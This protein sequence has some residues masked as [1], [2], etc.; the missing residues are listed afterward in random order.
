MGTKSP[1]VSFRP[2]YFDSLAKLEPAEQ[3]RLN[4]SIL[5][6][7]SYPEALGLNLERLDGALSDLM[8]VRAGRDRRVILYRQGETY[9]WWFAGHHDAA[10]ERAGRARLVVNP[11]TE[12]LGFVEPGSEPHAR[13]EGARRAVPV[14]D[15]RPRPFDHWRLSTPLLVIGDL[16]RLLR[17]LA[18]ESFSIEEVIALTE[19]Y[20][21]G[22]VKTVDDLDFGGSSDFS[23]V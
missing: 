6:F 12:F 2:D 15:R 10:Y 16:D 19:R 1:S 11:Q 14:R 9:I 13:S 20:K 8:S 3:K 21:P 7:R 23:G 22:K 17:S 5:K 4:D 18:D